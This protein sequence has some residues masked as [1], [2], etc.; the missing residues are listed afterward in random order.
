[1]LNFFSLLEVTLRY[2]KASKTNWSF[3]VMKYTRHWALKHTTVNYILNLKS[4]HIMECLKAK[5]WLL[6]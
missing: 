1:M 5:L 3:F 2:M 4:C 6:C